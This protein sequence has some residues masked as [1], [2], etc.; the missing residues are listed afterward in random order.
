MNAAKC[1]KRTAYYNF[2]V[3][4]DGIQKVF[5][6][7]KKQI[8]KAVRDGETYI[9]YTLPTSKFMFITQYTLDYFTLLGFNVTFEQDETNVVIAW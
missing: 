7:I 1:R 2:K 6:D 3:Y 8:R 5:K 4:C 9:Q